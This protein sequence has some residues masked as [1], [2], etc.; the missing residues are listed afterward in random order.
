ME[1][2]WPQEEGLSGRSGAGAGAL[3]QVAGHLPPRSPAW[4]NTITITV[5]TF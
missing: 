1:S 3:Q 5:R 4:S 2:E